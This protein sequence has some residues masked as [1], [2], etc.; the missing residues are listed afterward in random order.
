M[1]WKHISAVALA[2]VLIAVGFLSLTMSV[3]FIN[4]F[5]DTGTVGTWFRVLL[6]IVEAGRTLAFLVIL[7]VA[8]DSMRK[9]ISTLSRPF[10]RSSLPK[11]SCATL[12]AS[13]GL[14]MRL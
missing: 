10:R 12:A 14:W 7:C 6:T 3:V 1:I 11:Q 2:L 9:G 8:F 5:W 4:L 13:S